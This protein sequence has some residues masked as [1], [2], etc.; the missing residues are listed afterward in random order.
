MIRDLSL[1]K[2]KRGL[3]T[4]LSLVLK[5]LS[6]RDTLDPKALRAETDVKQQKEAGLDAAAQATGLDFLG[7]VRTNRTK[8]KK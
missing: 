3:A 6:T 7:S 8:N 5:V 4:Y 2:Q 1:K